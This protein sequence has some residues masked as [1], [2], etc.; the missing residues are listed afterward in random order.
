[1]RLFSNVLLFIIL[2]TIGGCGGGG[3]GSTANA[4]KKLAEDAE[5]TNPW[6]RETVIKSTNTNKTYVY[7]YLDNYANYALE[8]SGVYKKNKGETYTINEIIDGDIGGKITVTGTAEVTSTEDSYSVKYSLKLVFDEYE[9]YDIGVHGTAFVDYNSNETSDAYT[10]SFKVHAGYVYMDDS[11][12]YS[13]SFQGSGTYSEDENG[14]KFTNT[15]NGEKVT[16]SYDYTTDTYKIN[17]E[18]V[19][20][21]EY[22]SYFDEL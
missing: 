15:Y 6:D 8:N 18:E 13:E 21:D 5:K 19:D 3:G 14:E 20:Y 22:Y 11:G 10:S 4:D 9:D 17:D 1:M 7:Y 16:G 12:V 2:L